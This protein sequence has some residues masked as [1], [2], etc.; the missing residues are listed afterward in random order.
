MDNLPPDSMGPEG[1]PV[2]EGPTATE[3]IKRIFIGPPRDLSDRNIFQSISVVAFLAWVGLGA[4]GLSSSSYGPEEAFRT[5][6]E[7]TYLA[8]PIALLTMT[9]VIILSACYSRI[10]ER[11]PHGG[12]GYVVATALLGPRAG[13]LSGSAL[14]IDYVLT[15]TVSIAA[16]GDALFSFMPPGLIHLKL[17]TEVFL[18]L[19]LTAVNVRGVKEPILLLLPVFLTFLVTHVVLIVAG[20]A[21]HSTAAGQVTR[22]IHQQF[23]GGL[24]TLGLGGLLLLFVHAYS[25]G[26]GTYTGIEAVSNGLPIMREPRVRTAKHTMV[27]M[28]VSL[29]FMAGGLVI[30]YLLWN[31]QPVPGKTLNAVLIERV[32]AGWPMAPQLVILTLLAEGAL[33]IVGA[34]AGFIDGPRVMANMA[35]DSWMPRRLAALSDRLT[36]GNG[37]GLMGAAALA[38][39]LYTGGDVR[40]LVIMYSI[41]VFLTFSLSMLS[42]SRLLFQQRRTRPSWKRQFTLFV[43]GLVFCATILGITIFEKFGQ[44]GWLSLLATGLVVC[45]CLWVKG[46]YSTLQHQLV[47]L[48]PAPVLP[49]APVGAAAPP[50][51]PT[52]PTAAVLVGGFNGLSVHTLLNG[53]RAFPGQ[54]KNV[55]FLGAG[56]IDSGAFKGDDSM[57]LLRE[58]TEKGLKKC[59]AYAQ[60]NGLPATYRMA[61]GTDAVH[62]LEKLCVDAGKEF[63]R[64]TFL[65]GQ[66][67]FHREKWHHWLLHNRT[68]FLLQ[69]RLHLSGHVLVIL[70]ARL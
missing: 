63:P 67:V 65:S 16:A 30:C 60:A 43:L 51:D 68:A 34:Q 22:D 41:N 50:L 70:P 19:A 62:E 57:D 17:P 9:T 39:L 27:Y 42:M 24:S 40:H 38:A 15:I 5:L 55:V 3:R 52:Q 8:L 66:L 26:G 45:L 21:G 29:S 37:I 2:P 7:H 36:I 13:V 14:L 44:G 10:I 18:I 56:I 46:H 64:I 33:L 32:S 59:V 35:I 1:P 25:M 4:D 61:I 69:R 54:F 6:G 53:F 49:P 12:G 48:Y 28:A 11:F 23:Q 31:V 47:K 20:V 58:Q